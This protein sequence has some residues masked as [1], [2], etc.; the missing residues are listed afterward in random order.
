MQAGRLLK[1]IS[2]S[3]SD[4]KQTLLILPIVF[5]RQFPA[6]QCASYQELENGLL[7]VDICQQGEV[8]S[9]RGYKLVTSEGATWASVPRQWLRNMGAVPG[10][11]LDVFETDDPTKLIVKFRK[12]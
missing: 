9:N 8:P 5:L 3:D 4:R 11:L 10:D 2:V 6:A 1:S 7:R 12:N